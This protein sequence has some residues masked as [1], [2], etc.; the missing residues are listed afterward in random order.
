MRM[1]TVRMDEE[2]YQMA[3]VKAKKLGL[4]LAT[5]VKVFLRS[6]I[7]QKGVGFYVGDD[8]LTELF[9]RWM[10]KRQFEKDRG[11]RV[12]VIGPKLKDIFDLNRKNVKWY[13]Q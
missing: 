1:L 5:L 12:A 8:D 2:L 4:P 10:S 6:F 3:K 11:S 7:T 9:R 13:Q